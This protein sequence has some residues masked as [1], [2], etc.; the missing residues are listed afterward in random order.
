MRLD[1]D[2][3]RRILMELEASDLPLA[4]SVFA[5]GRVT[6]EQAAYHIEIMAQ[7]GLLRATVTRDLSGG[8]DAVAESL[9]WEGQDFLDAVRSDRVW[10]EV[11][12]AGATGIASAKALAMELAGELLLGR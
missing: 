8:V 11:V 5:D 6:V 10:S 1:M 12:A 4:A 9:T 2:L 7:A 3:V